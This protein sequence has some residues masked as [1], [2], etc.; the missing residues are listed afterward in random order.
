MKKILIGGVHPFAETEPQAV[1]SF[2]DMEVHIPLT[3]LHQVKLEFGE[4]HRWNSELSDLDICIDR[5]REQM[6]AQTRRGDPRKLRIPREIT[7]SIE[8]NIMTEDEMFKG[9]LDRQ[10][11]GKG[12]GL[13]AGGG[14]ED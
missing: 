1:L 8:T 13:G 2:G 9:A 3:V 7:S 4:H 6:W 5:I 14:E 11:S 10:F 12:A